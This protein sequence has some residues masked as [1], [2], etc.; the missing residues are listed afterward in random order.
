M[1]TVAGQGIIFMTLLFFSLLVSFPFA[2]SVLWVFAMGWR[3]GRGKV[4]TLLFICVCFV[5]IYGSVGEQRGGRA[6]LE[7]RLVRADA[8]VCSFIHEAPGDVCVVYVDYCDSFLY[9]VCCVMVKRGRGW[10]RGGE[11]G[12]KKEHVLSK[13]QEEKKQN[14][15][16]KN[17]IKK[18]TKDKRMRKRKKEQ[19]K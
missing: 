1:W 8:D 15:S 7:G 2:P 10:Q 4:I 5:S 14:K 12:R 9:L 16:K 11:T 19:K 6:G 3:R 13:D 18:S 17:K